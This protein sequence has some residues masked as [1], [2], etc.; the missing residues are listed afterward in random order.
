MFR[1]YSLF[2]NTPPRLSV[3]P[4]QIS[5]TERKHS[6]GPVP[7]IRVN[8]LPLKQITALQQRKARSLSN[9]PV[10]QAENN[11][12]TNRTDG[13]CHSHHISRS[14][15]PQSSRG[16]NFNKFVNSIGAK[17]HKRLLAPPSPS[18]I[19]NGSGN[20]SQNSQELQ[21][22]VYESNS[23][24]KDL[25]KRQLVATT[26]ERSS[27]PIHNCLLV[28]RRSEFYDSSFSPNNLYQQLKLPVADP[29]L[30]KV[31][32]SDLVGMYAL[33]VGSQLISSA[34]IS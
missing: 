15:Q 25:R 3:L 18:S 29:F 34:K 7:E 19:I 1:R 13:L 14:E 2:D 27:S 32:L 16:S 23:T 22:L 20:P 33:N 21:P 10:Y 31:N 5:S 8:Q 17:G 9:S 12:K 6:L 4:T 11:K 30:E 28:R 26:A 24:P